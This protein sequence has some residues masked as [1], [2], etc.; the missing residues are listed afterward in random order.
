[1]LQDPHPLPPLLQTLPRLVLTLVINLSTYS[2]LQLKLVNNRAVP[3]VEVGELLQLEVL[4][5]WV[6]VWEPELV[7]EVKGLARLWNSYEIIP[8]SNS[9]DNSSNNSQLCSNRS[10]NKSVRGTHSLLN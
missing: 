6:L 2:K 7:Q 9:S 1:V 4:V 10:C 3:V 8:T 5:H